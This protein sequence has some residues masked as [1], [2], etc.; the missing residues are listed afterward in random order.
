MLQDQL[1]YSKRVPAIPG[2]KLRTV[3]LFH[4]PGESLGFGVR[5][6]KYHTGIEVSFICLSPVHR[7]RHGISVS[8]K[9]WNI[10]SKKRTASIKCVCE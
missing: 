5:G 3:R 9:V 10:M 8:S 2:V 4:H 6:G 7:T 1:E